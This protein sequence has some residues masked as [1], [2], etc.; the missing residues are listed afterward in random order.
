MESD[1]PFRWLA[2]ALRRHHPL[3][4]PC[5]P[6]PGHACTPP[7]VCDEPCEIC[8]TYGYKV[9]EIDTLRQCPPHPT[10]R[11]TE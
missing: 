10:I 3:D 8:D 9:T 11:R 5:V 7:R 6:I 1:L 4:E 2:G